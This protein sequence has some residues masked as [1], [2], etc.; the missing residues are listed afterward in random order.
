MTIPYEVI[1]RIAENLEGS[2]QSLDAAL[3]RENLT[4]GS[5]EQEDRDQLDD[6][7]FCCDGCGWWH[8]TD[9]RDT[10]EAE[11]GDFCGS[12]IAERTEED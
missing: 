3:D 10:I 9:E 2:C 8:G 5:L 6:M 11:D 4:Q 1:R 12:C 7:V